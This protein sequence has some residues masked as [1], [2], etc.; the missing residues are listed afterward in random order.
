MPRSMSEHR[1]SLIGAMLVAIGPVSMALYTPALPTLVEAFDTTDG[2]VKLTVSLYFAGF[3][4]TQLVCGP[5]SDAFG[6]RPVTVAFL[7]LYLAGSL[8]AVLAP[9]IEWLLAARMVQGVGASVGVATAR[10]IVRD[11]YSG[12]T[13]S[14]IMNT[15][16]I[17]LAVAPA[18]APSIGGLTLAVA[19]WHALFVVML[20]FGLAVIG[21][22]LGQMRETTVPDRGLI[23][24]P[25]LIR[26]YRRLFTNLHFLTTVLT[27]AGTVG[28]VYTLATVLPFVLIDEAGLTPAQFGLGMLGQTGMFLLGSLTVRGLMRRRISA[29]RLVPAGLFF[30]GA[31]S[32]ALIASTA[33]LPLSYLSVMAPVGLY[34]FGIAFVMPA[35]TTASLAPFPDIAGAASAAMGF[36][37]MGGGLLGGLLCAA[38][39]QPVLAT[40]IVIPAMGATAIAAY[41]LYRS[42][43]HLAEPEPRPQLPAPQLVD[44]ERR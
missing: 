20:F 36:V 18:L 11:Q 40:Q 14:R 31:G 3:A 30:V 35:M 26:S 21:L 7:L 38:I 5:L 32:L 23:R 15:M 41:L 43:P 27:V 10:A 24:V 8:M 37:Q 9:G 42:R 17:I 29:Y 33:L 16:G 12:E 13:S 2:M 28:A 25:A 22:V 1:T 44:T 39:G 6:R 34:A 4:L 19:N